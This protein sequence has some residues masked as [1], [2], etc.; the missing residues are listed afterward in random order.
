MCWDHS[1][2][3]DLYENRLVVVEG[4]GRWGGGGMEWEVGISRCKLLY[5]EWIKNKVLLQHRELC[6]L[7]CDKP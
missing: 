3:K 5:T 6:S 4:R 7:S 2:T 1:S